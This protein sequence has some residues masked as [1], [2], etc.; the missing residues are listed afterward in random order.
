MWNNT[1]PHSIILIECKISLLFHQRLLLAI[2][3]SI[4]ECKLPNQEIWELLLVLLPEFDQVD[5]SV[6]F[7]TRL[8]VTSTPVSEND[9]IDT[10]LPKTNLLE[11]IQSKPPDS[12]TLF[13]EVIE[14]KEP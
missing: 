12:K 14:P 6:P 10:E 7:S 13:L 9:T 11:V 5:S 4:R 8:E 1:I 2:A 3:R